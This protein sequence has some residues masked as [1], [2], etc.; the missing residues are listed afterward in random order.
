MGRSFLCGK[1]RFILLILRDLI[2]C[3]FPNIVKK[4]VERK[5]KKMKEVPYPEIPYHEYELRMRKL[6]ELLRKHK[7]DGLCLFSPINLRYYFGY[8]KGSYGSS[9]LWRRAASAIFA[10]GNRFLSCSNSK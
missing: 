6:K 3:E 4:I 7:L 5:E 8:R 10:S 2:H 9:D 1:E